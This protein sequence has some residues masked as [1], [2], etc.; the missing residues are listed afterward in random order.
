LS[1]VQFSQQQLRTPT[2]NRLTQ[3]L[4]IKIHIQLHVPATLSYPQFLDNY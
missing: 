2:I 4:F 1:S 3:H